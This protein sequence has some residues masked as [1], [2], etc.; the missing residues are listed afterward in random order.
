MVIYEGYKVYPWKLKQHSFS[1][2]PTLQFIGF[3]RHACAVRGVPTATQ[4]AQLVKTF[5]TDR[6]LKQWGLYNEGKRHANDAI[7]HGCYWLLFGMGKKT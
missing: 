1:D 3:L 7:R 4:M 5:C 2:V 6:K